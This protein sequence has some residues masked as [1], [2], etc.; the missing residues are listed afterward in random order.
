MMFVLYVFAKIVMAEGQIG[1]KVQAKQGA[2]CIGSFAFKIA[3]VSKIGTHNIIRF[4]LLF[5]LN[6]NDN[7]NNQHGNYIQYQK[8]V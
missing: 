6:G 7:C 4:H 2:V 1:S 5:I 3:K 8:Y